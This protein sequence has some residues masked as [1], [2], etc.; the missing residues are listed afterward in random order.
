MDLP[1]LLVD[2]LDGARL[3]VTILGEVLGHLFQ[4][5]VLVERCTGAQAQVLERGVEAQKRAVLGELRL[6]QSGSG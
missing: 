6:D 3:V 4:L 2:V 5:P 1:G